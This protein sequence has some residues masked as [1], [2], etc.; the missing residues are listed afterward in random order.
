MIVGPEVGLELAGKR[1]TREGFLGVARRARD[2]RVQMHEEEKAARSFEAAIQAAPEFAD[3][4]SGLAAIRTRQGTAR[5]AV[6]RQ[7]KAVRLSSQIAPPNGLGCLRGFV[8]RRMWFGRALPSQNRKHFFA[9]IGAS[10][11][12]PT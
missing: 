11:R 3:A 9:R 7:R 4:Y 12:R 1:L 5:Q 10:I 2:R 6:T 8:G